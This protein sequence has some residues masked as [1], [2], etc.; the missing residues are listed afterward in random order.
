[1]LKQPEAQTWN[2]ITNVM[3]RLKKKFC[4]FKKKAYCFFPVNIEYVIKHEL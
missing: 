2:K 3:A 1:M 4:F